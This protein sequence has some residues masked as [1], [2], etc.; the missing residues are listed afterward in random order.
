MD[1]MSKSV[2]GKNKKKKIFYWQLKILPNMLSVKH[3]WKYP[4]NTFL[5]S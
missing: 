5:I 1:E 3:Y 2:F 4:H